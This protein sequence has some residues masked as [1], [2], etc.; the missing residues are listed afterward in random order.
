MAAKNTDPEHVLARLQ[1]ILGEVWEQRP[2]D[3]AIQRDASFLELGVDSLTLV[4][5]LDKVAAEFRIDW[6][7]ETSPGTASSLRSLSALVV[8][9]THDAD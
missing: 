6:E 9:R 2:A 4:L 8:R 3:V 5:L 7:R 1:S